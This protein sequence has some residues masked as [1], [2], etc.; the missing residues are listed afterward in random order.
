MM[1]SVE[2]KKITIFEGPDC[3]GKT[4]TAQEYATQTGALYFHHGPYKGVTSGLPRL[5]FESMLP[6]LHG[7]RDVVLDRCWLSEPIY[8]YTFRKGENRVGDVF[9][10]M[11]ERAALR[12][13]AVVVNC[14]PPWERVAETFLKRREE[15]YLDNLH[16]LRAV[17]ED[18]EDL[19]TGLSEVLHDYTSYEHEDGHTPLGLVV[20][21]IRQNVEHLRRG[22][23]AHRRRILTSGNSV[24]GVLI[25]GD[26]FANHKNG[27]PLL[28]LP[29]Q[30]FNRNGCSAW[31]AQ[32]L[33]D[34][35][36]EEMSL[37]WVNADELQR[38]HE[39]LGDGFFHREVIALGEK[40]SATL[41]V[42]GVPHDVIPHPQYWKRFK[43]DTYP[44]IPA[45]Q[46]I[47]HGHR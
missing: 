43:R 46:S 39:H 33:I 19:P 42:L 22:S 37:M 10:R 6:A 38:H 3:S 13:G 26:S 8:G 20:E 35:N 32:Q 4:T 18:Y 36:I 5:F 44:L 29:F 45:L 40:A 31:L 27:D 21:D 7:H 24:G 2:C 16:Q 23:P 41:N 47:V 11:L 28:Q 9:T 15:E 30:S 12:C 1:S 25:V 14:R 34:A 17:Y